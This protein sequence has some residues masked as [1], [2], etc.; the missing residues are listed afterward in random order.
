LIKRE[1]YMGRIRP[2]I[3]KDLV[4]I[5]TG[6]RRSGKSVMLDLIKDELVLQGTAK[7]Q[8]IS[9]N[10]EE[11][12][13]AQLL[14]IEALHNYVSE[15]VRGIQGKAYLFFDEIQEVDGWEKC[16][17][18]FRLEFD[19]DIYV[20]GS[21][22]K[23]LSSE[24]ATYLAGRYVQFV[25]YPF[26]FSE[27]SDTY[28]TVDALASP[29]E[30]FMKY[31][32]FGGMPFLVNLGFAEAPSRQYLQ[33]IYN[34]VVLKDIIERNKIR[35]V[36]L[37]ERVIMY[38]LANIGKTFSAASISKYF[39][40]ENRIAAPETVLNYINACVK[41][42]LFYPVKRQ[43]VIGKK[44]LT[45]NEKYYIADHGLREAIY[46]KNNRDIEIVLENIVFIEL[47]R[48]GYKITVGKSGDL[49][50]DFIAEDH[51]GVVYVQVS[52]LLASETTIEREF[53]LLLNIRDNYPKYV[54]TLDE[55]NL[56]RNGIKHLN[57]RDFL[58]MP[59]L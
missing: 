56:G 19:C 22:A 3:N 32:L 37:L 58:M 24:Y 6:I 38:L 10:F 39:K 26:S 43:E 11:I 28:K 49:E 45:I 16:I 36:D 31:V 41:A 59:E 4:K 40:S 8:F 2:F 17:N 33:D 34:S 57:I 51:R 20:T 53:G 12:E 14:S 48:R 30:I 44:I 46:G 50:I 42:Y 52:Y 13:Y 5:L 1:L 7:S 23:L 29:S 15:R 9:I 18:S 55:F 47:L 21:N 27:F 25:V 54:V 35:D